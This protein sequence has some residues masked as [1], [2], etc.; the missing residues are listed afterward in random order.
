MNPKSDRTQQQ[1][2]RQRQLVKILVVT[3]TLLVVPLLLLF[4][5][6]VLPAKADEPKHYTDLTFPPTPA[7]QVPDYTRFQL[8]NGMGVYLMEDHELPL[9]S[10]TM[11]VRTGDRW[12]PTDK[13][14]LAE[15]MAT[16]MRTGGT[17]KRTGDDL[18]QFLE[19]RA[20]SVETGMGETSGSAGFS[21]LT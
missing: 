19:R 15:I 4:L 11:L 8:A 14:G 17:Q 5:T 3:L 21:T 16:V 2:K 1:Q 12:E 13:V 18:N 10:G 7:I 9:I 6:Q 20:A